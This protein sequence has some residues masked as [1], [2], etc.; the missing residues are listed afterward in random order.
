[1]QTVPEH[2]LQ[3][4]D[5]KLQRLQSMAPDGIAGILNI[6]LLSMTA[7]KKSCVFRANTAPWMKNAAGTLHGG[8]GATLLDHT[9]G[10]LLYCVKDGDG[11]CPTL[12]LQSSY[13]R[14]LIPGKDVLVRV[15]VVS[16]SKHFG[17]MAAEVVQED[18]P[19]IV[20]ASGTSIYY[21]TD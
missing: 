14:P 16:K 4:F 17:H 15:R 19:D 3:R 12:E 11:F 2:E 21:L 13:H 5:D 20:C 18:A 6:Q 7:D 8:M 1:M 10:A 9:M